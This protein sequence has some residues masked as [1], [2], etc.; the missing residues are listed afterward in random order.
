MSDWHDD[1]KKYVVR[2]HKELTG[3]DLPIESIS[4]VNIDFDVDFDD[5]SIHD[6]GNMYSF[7]LMMEKYEFAEK[8]HNEL[9]SRGCVVNVDLD[10]EKKSGVINITFSP[11]TS[12]K[13]IDIN[14]KLTPTGIVVDFDK[15]D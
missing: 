15:L 14:M 7:A 10:D 1:L 2:K 5:L 12:T 6:L 11:K 13:S 8:I 9:K 3:E 4:D